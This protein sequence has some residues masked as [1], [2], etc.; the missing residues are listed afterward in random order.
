[1]SLPA[2]CEAPLTPPRLRALAAADL[3]LCIEPFALV[4]CR[5]GDLV[6]RA[7][8]EAF[9]LRSGE[10]LVLRGP[11]AA[12]LER[13]EAGA[14]I[15]LLAASPAWVEAFWGLLGGA[16][17]ALRL[18][19]EADRVPAGAALARRA[20]Q[21]LATLPG[22]D[23]GNVVALSPSQLATLIEIAFQSHGPALPCTRSRRQLAGQRRALVRTL[24]DYD[25]EADGEFSLHGLAERLGLSSRQTARLVRGET[26]RSFRELKAAARLERARKLLASSDLSILE[27]ALRAGWNSASQFHEAFRQSVGVTPARYREAH[28]G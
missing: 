10:L 22:P 12:T 13:A 5:E 28:R 20:A 17:E 4:T 2:S 27:V 14:R 3:P 6:A 18:A 21:L 1:M 16:G 19:G 9:R 15:T 26:G 23:P 7:G 24:A 11:G 8:G 25:P